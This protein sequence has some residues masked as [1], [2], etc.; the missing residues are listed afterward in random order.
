MARNPINVKSSLMVGERK[1]RN[2]F[3][4]QK[5]IEAVGIAPAGT[6]IQY[7]TEKIPY[8]IYSD[9]NPDLIIVLPSGKKFY[10]EIKGN[11][12]AW[13]PDVMRKMISVREQNPGIDIRFVFY[14]NGKFGLPRKD[15]TKRTQSEWAEKNGFTYSIGTIPEEWFIDG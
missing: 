2:L 14:S 3:E 11:G 15:G 10:I 1:V 6:V 4:E 12:R 8:V 13:T 7:E 5:Y 9:Y